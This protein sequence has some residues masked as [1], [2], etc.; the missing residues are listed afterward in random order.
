MSYTALDGAA[1]G[2]R[3]FGLYQV[4]LPPG[5]ETVAHDH[6]HDR[7]EDAYAF[8]AGSG[9]VIVDGE[10]VEAVPGRF[11]AVSPESTR[12]VRAGGAGLAFIAICAPLG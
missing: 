8:V 7:A 5:G 9:H 1:L 12:L 2:I 6:T 3:A 4:E 11:V 10:E